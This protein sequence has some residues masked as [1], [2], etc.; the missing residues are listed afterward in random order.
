MLC[1]SKF[2]S[3]T[4]KFLYAHSVYGRS[5][6]NTHSVCGRGEDKEGKEEKYFLVNVKLGGGGRWK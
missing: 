1:G 4:R 6:L 5:S 3:M 2:L